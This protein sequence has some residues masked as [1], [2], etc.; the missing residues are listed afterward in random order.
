M[1][2]L[3]GNDT[4][5][6]KATFSQLFYS[7]SGKWST[8]NG[9]KRPLFVEKIIDGSAIVCLTFSILNF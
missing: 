9:E 1:Y 2:D 4:F 8:L 6:R 3:R 7:P 5:S